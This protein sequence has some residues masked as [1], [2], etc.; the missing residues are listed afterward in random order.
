MFLCN[1]Y[2][3]ILQEFSFNLLVV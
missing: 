1:W 2:Y 3:E